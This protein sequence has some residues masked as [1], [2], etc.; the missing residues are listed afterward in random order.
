MHS[1][2]I[3]ISQ[4]GKIYGLPLNLS[5]RLIKGFVT[6]SKWLP[7]VWRNTRTFIGR[8]ERGFD[9]PGYHFS[10]EGLTAARETLK[11]FVSRATRL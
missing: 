8:I 2:Q 10:P 4:V 1:D 5:G 3:G 7:A 9:F 11:R 6:Y